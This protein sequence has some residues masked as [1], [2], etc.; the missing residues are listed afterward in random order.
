VSVLLRIFSVPLL[1]LRTPPPLPAPLFPFEMV[2]PEKVTT[3][4]AATFRLKTRLVWLPLI[5]NGRSCRSTC[6]R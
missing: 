6:W 5:S 1:L 2:K 4:G 3:P